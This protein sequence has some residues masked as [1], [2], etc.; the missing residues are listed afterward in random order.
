MVPYIIEEEIM[1]HM[2]ESKT[3][4]TL[5]QLRGCSQCPLLVTTLISSHGLFLG[6]S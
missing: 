3:F 1:E 4:S 5:L 6:Q 2:G